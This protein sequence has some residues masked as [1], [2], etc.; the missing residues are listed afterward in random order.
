MRKE[1]GDGPAR[2]D[3][4]RIAPGPRAIRLH[5]GGPG[6]L[7]VPCMTQIG[8]TDEVREL[9]ARM[10]RFIDD[11]VIKAEPELERRRRG[12]PPPRHRP[13]DRAL[14]RRPRSAAWTRRSACPAPATRPPGATTARSP[15][16]RPRPRRAACGRSATPPRSAAAG[17]RSWT[18][19]TST[20]S[21]GAREFGQ[22][23]VG[24]A[25]MQDSIML[26]LYAS[27]EQR[28]RYLEP[29]V[30]GG[31]VPV[32]RADRAGGRRQRSRRRCR[33]RPTSTATSG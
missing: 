4:G 16:S 1:R 33:R 27:D 2:L 3:R 11:V 23:A 29:L 12:R 5:L 7:T 6:S 17:C 25:S 31:R 22:V 8:M 28:E 9:R 13:A 10:K 19:S 21:S 24:T 15:T 26:H 20:R 18:S 30:A 32:G 14:P